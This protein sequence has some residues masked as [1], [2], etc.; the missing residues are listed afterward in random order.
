L[1]VEKLVDRAYPLANLPM[2]QQLIL[3]HF[4]KGIANSGVRYEIRLR[5]PKDVNQA[6]TISGRKFSVILASE[7][8]FRD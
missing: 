1:Q 8:I 6:K 4:I 7:K 5:K 3:D 2:R